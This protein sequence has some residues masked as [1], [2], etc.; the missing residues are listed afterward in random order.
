MRSEVVE[1][2]REAQECIL[3]DFWATR[4]NVTPTDDMHIDAQSSGLSLS[5]PQSS[6]IALASQDL[7]SIFQQPPA[8]EI[9]TSIASISRL[10]N[11]TVYQSSDSG[12][13]SQNPSVRDSAQFNTDWNQFFCQLE[14]GLNVPTV[15]LEP[16][17]ELNTLTE[18]LEP[19]NELNIPIGAPQ[20]QNEDFSIDTLLLSYFDATFF[21]LPNMA[22]QSLLSAH[23]IPEHPPENRLG[24]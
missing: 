8:S 4:P 3:Q 12:Y 6:T 22:E 9:H 5:E 7:T 11:G 13:G 18:A 20:S 16:Q 1:I 23:V 2:I 17:D 14:D 19:R 10:H 21:E 24:I 15:A